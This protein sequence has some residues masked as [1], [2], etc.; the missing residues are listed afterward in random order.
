MLSDDFLIR[1]V[2]Q[3]AIVLSRIIGLKKTGDYQ[4]A[5][6]E[7]YQALEQV[8]GLNMELIRIMDDDSVYGIL[9]KDERIDAER[10]GVVAD[11][12][13]E[14][15]DIFKR[16]NLN[17]ES[18][19]SYH[20]SLNYYLVK[21]NEEEPPQQGITSAKIDEIIDQIGIADLPAMTLFN[22][23]CYYENRGE[24]A[25]A[26]TILGELAARPEI[27][28][29]IRKERLSF[30]RRLLE[31]NPEEIAAGGLS[32]EQIKSKLNDM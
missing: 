6:E 9:T 17:L 7:I 23:F 14:E 3:W 31:K 19:S 1:M 4:E 12:F 15:G 32:L 29:D 25:H 8:L 10:L 13:K 5:L 22:L 18:R 27:N 28:S 16:Q 26:D 20:R 30:Y 24:Y 21:N 2:R 11:L